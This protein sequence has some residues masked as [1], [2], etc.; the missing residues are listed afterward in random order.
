MSAKGSGG[1]R[2]TPGVHRRLGSTPTAPGSDKAPI[3]P[4]AADH[5]TPATGPTAPTAHLAADAETIW[6]K[7]RHG[8]VA[9]RGFH[10]QEAI[11]TWMSAT[12]LHGATYELLVPEGSHEDFTCEGTGALAVQAKSKQGRAGNFRA[13]E[14][15]G[16][17]RDLQ[18]RRT[19]RPH[20]GDTVL[21]IERDIDEC[22]LP[23]S[24]M[25]VGGLRAD[26]PLAIACARVT[27]GNGLQAD[28]FDDIR[29]QVVGFD[30]ARRRA[31]EIIGAQFDV[32]FAIAERIA[33]EFNELVRDAADRNA[34]ARYVD[35]SAIGRTA[36]V[37]T[38]ERTKAETD[39]S[40]LTAA[41]NS[42]ACEPADL[43]TPTDE[44]RYF[45]GLHAQP[46]H[47]A[48]DLP[49]W[50][51]D[52]V[53]D[54]LTNLNTSGTVLISGPSGVG[55]STVMWMCARTARRVTWFRVHRLTFADVD[56]LCRLA[57]GRRP[58]ESAPVG[59]LVDGVGLSDVAGWDQLVRRVA[60]MPYVYV[61]GTARV[62]DTFESVTLTQCA[63]IDVSLDEQ[64]AERIHRNLVQAGLTTQAHWRE[65]YDQANGLTL[66]F[67]HYLTR[68]ERLSDVL[69]A[70]VRRLVRDGAD[71]EIQVLALTTTAHMHGVP[72]PIESA[73]GALRLTDSDLRRAVARL[74]DEH[75][76]AEESGALVGLHLVRS[77]ALSVA[78]HANPPP[79]FGDTV[80]R[81]ITH[82]PAADLPRLVVG[83]LRDRGDVDTTVVSGC[84]ARIREEDA[85][86]PLLAPVLH[87]LRSADFLRH[88]R[89]WAH[90][91]R[92][93]NVPPAHW[94]LTVNL[95]FLDSE[96]I[97]GLH[98]AIVTAVTRLHTLVDEPTP[99][100]NELV[101]DVTSATIADTLLA[102][103]TPG[104]IAALLTACSGAPGS[105]ID[106]L[107]ARTWAGTPAGDVLA[108]CSA[109][110]FG[111]VAGVGQ[112]LSEQIAEQMVEAAGGEDE[113]L[114]RVFARYPQMYEVGRTTDAEG[115]VAMARL[116]YVDDELTPGCDSVAVD[117][118]R[119]LLRSMPGCANAD[120]TT[121]RAGDV[122]YAI[123][124]LTF[125]AS[126][127]LAR[128]AITNLQVEWNRARCVLVLHE[129]G[130]STPGEHAARVASLLAQAATYFE[131]LLILWLTE[132]DSVGT[133]DW[134]WLTNERRRL[135]DEADQ[136][137]APQDGVQ[138]FQVA[139]PGMADR[140]ERLLD[141]TEAPSGHVP[142]DGIDGMKA[143]DAHSVVSSIT[144]ST[145]DMLAEGRIGPLPHH[146]GLVMQNLDDTAVAERWELA[147][148]DTPP[149]ELETLRRLLTDLA[150][151]AAAMFNAVI[152]ARDVKRA[153]RSG[154]NSKAVDRAADA[155]RTATLGHFRSVIERLNTSLAT[156]GV[157]AQVIERATDPH[158]GYWPNADF[159]VLVACGSVLEWTQLVEPASQAV[160][161]A[162]GDHHL[163]STLIC[164]VI[165]GV[166]EPQLAVKVQGSS[167]WPLNDC[168]YDW[169]PNESPNDLSAVDL[170]S[171]VQHAL[172][173]ILRRSS[174]NYLATKRDLAES[175]AAAYDRTATMFTDA[176]S[177]V[178]SYG[179]DEAIEAISQGL[180]GLAEQV[181]A[182]AADDGTL[183]NL[184][185]DYFDSLASKASPT[186][187]AVVGC[188]LVAIQW[189]HDVG[190]AVDMVD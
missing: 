152:A 150:D 143:D 128:N 43:D 117:L 28:A 54:V 164:P 20:G 70:Q 18:A 25:L 141:I 178:R 167:T 35:R 52:L 156:A 172:A 51:P 96:P 88:A 187:E 7:G 107:G 79:T 98:P 144:R 183:G 65:A 157:R 122:E 90:V 21:V 142:P 131:R 10:Y 130:F 62:E 56:D 24:D 108:S 149:T 77:R 155:C 26:H 58:V 71:A 137:T 97:D 87:A 36:L 86:S 104:R 113:V 123:G 161:D 8:A 76:V 118:A 121:T 147:G 127:L 105:L 12:M 66:E 68:G 61:V 174:L 112:S 59:F 15:A 85:G 95:A 111:N 176:L 170:P 153:A 151:I 146:L 73:R 134:D 140:I 106:A 177:R 47:V 19:K 32:E 132:R 1:L 188:P 115:S 41:I 171:D 13:S 94:P 120:I 57:E 5:P 60:A 83:V 46:G 103:A 37:A 39:P 159:A 181:D 9:G 16:H 139:L 74:K 179:Q 162:R 125:G 126:G 93:E 63:R 14:V 38:A 99:L 175:F 23:A 44:P 82:V 67:T 22:P 185:S 182:E 133:W 42:G 100:R 169:F 72:L 45:E 6:A 91:I 80:A 173:A 78:V 49:T 180:L 2:K 75:F 186:A 11:G 158:Q 129:L 55:K 168:Y 50:R 145:T 4:Q 89:R 64:V 190:T 17:L 160:R 163:P 34:E 101:E 138:L 189:T 114:R 110:E 102:Q 81:L 53:E 165:N 31:A 154:P 184:A 48:A 119:L 166:R 136:L 33:L 109:E 124:D 116:A 69:T 92:E 84:A 29:I 135:A 27:S 40:K 3:P 30:E 148:I